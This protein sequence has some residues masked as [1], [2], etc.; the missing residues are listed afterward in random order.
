M[1]NLYKF[2]DLIVNLD[3]VSGISDREIVYKNGEKQVISRAAADDL[4]E[5]F[6]PS[7]KRWRESLQELRSKE[8]KSS[9][10][11]RQSSRHSPSSHYPKAK[12]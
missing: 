3:D 12:A 4:Q 8:K 7:E 9:P 6:T 11:T 5:W 1:N 10:S 2:S